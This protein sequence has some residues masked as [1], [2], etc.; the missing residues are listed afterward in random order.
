M[1][2]L[3]VVLVSALMVLSMVACNKKPDENLVDTY[4]MIDAFDITTFD[5]VFN[6]KSS[7][8]DY[9]SNFIEGLLTQDSH[10]TLVAGM[11]DKWEP[12]ADMKTWTFHIRDNASWS[13]NE[14]EVYAK[15]TAEDFVTGLKHAADVQ[16][17]TLSL[18]EDLIVNLRAYA[19]GTATWDEVGCKADENNN[20]VYTLTQPCGYFDGMTTYSILWPINAD[21]LA[22]KGEG[23]GAVEPSSILYNGCYLLT[24]LVAKQEVKFDAN[25]NYY[26]KA[27]VFVKH[28]VVTY[29]DG[30][31]PAQ[32]FNMFVNGEVT[33]TAINSNLPDVVA[34]ADELYK[35]NQY[36]TMTT[37][38]T[39]WGAFNFDRL[40][41]ALYN[42]PSVAT[43]TKDDAQ[44]ADAKKAILNK[45][46]R[47]AV[48]AAYSDKATLTITRGEERALEVARNTLVPY[49]FAAKTD[50]TAYGAL[51]EKYLAEIE[52][53]FAG[54]DLN[55]GQ[56]AWYNV[57]RAK[58][59][60]EKAKE[61]LGDSVSWPI[62]LDIPVWG[63]S[64]N[65]K[66]QQLAFKDSVESAIGDYVQLNL[67]MLD[68]RSAY[69]SAFY[70]VPTG[71]D[72][73]IDLAFAA[74]WGPDYGDPLTY[75]NCYNSD[76]GDMLAYSGLNL[77][78]EGETESGA[79][80]KEAIGLYEVKELLDK[81]VLLAGDERI[82][83]FAKIEAI[84][85]ANGVLRPY[86]TSGASLAI[87][88]V[89]PF[90]GAYGLYGQASYNAVPYFKYMK[91]QD[92]P[93]TAADYEAAKAKWLKGE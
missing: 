61:E 87:S 49:T 72:N 55:D 66:N 11:A 19:E 57:E 17:E 60:A 18:V 45:W 77:V 59:F 47:L 85:L 38:T 76:N 42:D 50:G 54:I 34:K 73:A 13:T 2:K 16:S 48:Y 22:A 90:T 71:A 80:A 20:V 28:V 39:Y 23:F 92:T 46:F 44:K 8:G 9:L 51:V 58:K 69:L 35:D 43:T 32:N 1:K 5:Y 93:I 3:L 84:L 70:T 26:D 81:A 12:S 63:T 4:S 33:S 6:N 89:V 30:A 15:V 21:F 91:V 53:E 68:E 62:I 88:K 37:S 40:S 27:N 14:G 67:V 10:G 29:T 7:N 78:S 25:P 64:E 31:D 24:S 41:Y 36:K 83:A 79:A 75:I 74:G 86:S 52:P 56:D 82:E 65:S